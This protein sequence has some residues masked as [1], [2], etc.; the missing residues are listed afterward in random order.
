MAI[1]TLG[2]TSCGSDDDS[3]DDNSNGCVICELTEEGI[4]TESEICENEDGSFTVFSEGSSITFE[5]SEG[6][7]FDQFVDFLEE[8][9]GSCN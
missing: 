5:E 2:F 8:S 7:T 1:I 4:T 6:I 3:S 9:G